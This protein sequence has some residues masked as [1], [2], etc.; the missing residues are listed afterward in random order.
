MRHLLGVLPFACVWLPASAA[1]P[2]RPLVPAFDAA[3]ITRVCD[4]GL[5]RSQR[6]VAAMAARKGG[7]TFFDEWNRVQI[8]M[9]DTSDPIGLM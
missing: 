5:A 8:E 2:S 4:E 1:G 7:A 3:R 9:Q 6:M